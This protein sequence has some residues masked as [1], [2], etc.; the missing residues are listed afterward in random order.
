MR[1]FLF[2]KDEEAQ[3][4]F[5]SFFLKRNV[6]SCETS[7]LWT[8]TIER[9]AMT[10]VYQT[11]VRCDQT[12]GSAG[13][14]MKSKELSWKI[15]RKRKTMKWMKWIWNESN[16]EISKKMLKCRESL[17]EV[18]ERQTFLEVFR[19]FIG[20]RG[21]REMS[22]TCRTVSIYQAVSEAKPPSQWNTK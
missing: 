13:L 21:S 17:R 2:S 12:V 7:N 15:S 14:D 5:K 1:C 4:R 20:S 10:K 8:H 11:G 18:G 19:F 9:S 6:S 3:D 22:E 16:V